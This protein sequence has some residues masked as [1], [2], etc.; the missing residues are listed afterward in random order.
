MA[1]AAEPMFSPICG[2]TRITTGPGC[3]TQFLVLSVPAP[4]IS[5]S[6][7]RKRLS[8]HAGRPEGTD[9]E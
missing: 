4:G 2:S 5:N 6:T 8:V 7:T 1:R 3:C 9:P